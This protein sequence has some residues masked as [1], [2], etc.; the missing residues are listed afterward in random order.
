M[1]NPSVVRNRFA[2][3][4]S[5]TSAAAG[6]VVLVLFLQVV[7]EW[8]KFNQLRVEFKY[9]KRDHLSSRCARAGGIKDDQVYPAAD[10]LL[11]QQVISGQGGLRYPTRR[12]GTSHTSCWIPR[13]C[14]D[15]ATCDSTLWMLSGWRRVTLLS[16]IALHIFTAQSWFSFTDLGTGS[17]TKMMEHDVYLLMHVGS[18]PNME[19]CQTWFK[20]FDTLFI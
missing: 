19:R 2:L 1:P 12:G 11:T 5:D 17:P 13:R 14:L 4:P 16:A 3:V 20:W 15:Q 7:V 6:D 9:T 8:M 10:R 18:T